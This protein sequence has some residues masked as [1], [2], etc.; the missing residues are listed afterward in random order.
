MIEQVGSG[1]YFARVL[2]KKA[3]FRP[4]AVP[5]FV[6]VFSVGNINDD[7]L[8]DGVINSVNDAVIPHAIAEVAVEPA[9]KVFDV[10]VPPRI[11]G[12]RLEATIQP[13]LKC[14]VRRFKDVL[15]RLCQQHLIHVQDFRRRDVTG[16]TRPRAI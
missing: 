3:P 12:E 14:G 7:H 1:G 4:V 8:G 11:A 15:R 6:Y 10:V 5:S 13:F 9:M 2:T 16:V